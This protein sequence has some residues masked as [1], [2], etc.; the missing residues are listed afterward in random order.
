MRQ[1]L[2]VTTLVG[3]SLAAR[4]AQAREFRVRL[5]KG[6]ERNGVWGTKEFQ[7]RVSDS[8][9]MTSL[10][11][12][13]RE[14]LRQVAAFYAYPTPPDSKRAIRL[15][16][17]DA[18]PGGRPSLA[19]AEMTTRDENGKRIFEFAYVIAHKKVLAGRPLCDV[20]QRVEITPTGEIHVRYDL[21]WLQTLRW[22]GATV[23]LTADIKRSGFREFMAVAGKRVLTGPIR[24]SPAVRSCF[25]HWAVEQLTLKRENDSCHFVVAER[26]PCGLVWR[27]GLVFQIR[28]HGVARKGFIYEG[29]KAVLSYSILLPVELQ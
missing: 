24:P 29:Q 10:K 27:K 4:A 9:R 22:S 19:P 11:V 14:V 13:G 8:G 20:R 2:I 15:I 25:N 16:Q 6:D 23:I 12:G 18:S 7:V 1:L 21:A 28:P 26:A 17:G 5:L 3:L